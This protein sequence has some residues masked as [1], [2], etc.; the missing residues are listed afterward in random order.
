MCSTTRTPRCGRPRRCCA[1]CAS[2]ATAWG[3]P[4]TRSPIRIL[5]GA[6]SPACPGRRWTAS[7]WRCG[8]TRAFDYSGSNKPHQKGRRN[9]NLKKGKRRRGRNSVLVLWAGILP[10]AAR[11]GAEGVATKD[12]GAALH[13]VMDSDRTVYTRL[14]VNRL[15]NEDKVIKASEHWKDDKALPLPAQMFR[16]GSEMAAEKQKLY[17]YS[18]LSEWPVN[19]QNAPRTPVEI[20][21]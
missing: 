4:S 21:G 7:A 19:K 20:A 8:V 9:D 13:A 3:S 18:L 5:P 1:R 15:Q 14:V 17:T 2:A 6:T 11:P 10:T 12:L 16:F